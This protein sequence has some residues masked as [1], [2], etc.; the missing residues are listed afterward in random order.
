MGIGILQRDT[1]N[2]FPQ[3]AVNNC[4]INCPLL[5]WFTALNIPMISSTY[6]TTPRLLSSSARIKASGVKSDIMT[7]RNIGFGGSVPQSSFLPRCRSN[8]SLYR[9]ISSLNL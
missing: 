4:S 5:Y 1:S 6:K 8:A 3:N 2:A 9:S 7:L